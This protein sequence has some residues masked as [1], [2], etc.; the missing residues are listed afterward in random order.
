MF[1]TI[2]SALERGISGFFQRLEWLWSATAHFIGM[3]PPVLRFVVYV[4]LCLAVLCIALAH[5]KAIISNGDKWKE[6][7]DSS[8][9]FSYFCGTG[10]YQRACVYKDAHSLVADRAWLLFSAA[11]AAYHIGN[12]KSELKLRLFLLSLVHIPLVVI[13]F[14]EMIFRTVFGFLYLLVAGAIHW[15]VLA[16]L[17]MYAMFLI[18]LC[19]I[20][21][22]RRRREQHCPYCYQTFRLPGYICPSCGDVHKDLTPG[23]TGLFFARCRCGK[24]L[25]SALGT[26][27]SHLEGVCPLCGKP[28]ATTGAKEFTLQM[29]GGNASGK[30]AYLAS[31]QHI[32][33]TTGQH[34]KVTQLNLFPQEQ[35]DEL[36][37]MFMDG[38][39]SES[40]KA[41]V[42]AYSMVYNFKD[43]VKENMVIY[44]IPDEVLISGIYEQNP[45]NFAYTDGIL[46]IFDPTSSQTVREESL[47]KGEPVPNGTYSAD[48]N[49]AED[50]VVEFIQQFSR[51]SNRSSSKV[52]KIPVAVIIN[53]T[54][55]KAVK[56]KIGWD[57]IQLK[58]QGN[59]SRFYDSIS[60]ARSTICRDYMISLGMANAINNLESVFSNVQY[61]PV[62]AA[63]H[64]CREGEPLCPEGV[65]D[66]VAWIAGEQGAKIG[67]LLEISGNTVKGNG[68]KDTVVEDA[69][70]E[71]YKNAEKLLSEKEFENAEKEFRRLGN[72]QDSEMRAVAVAGQRYQY[73]KEL[74]VQKKYGLAAE[75]F[76][77]LGSYQD[78][79]D[80][81]FESLY[82]HGDICLDSKSFN[83][84]IAAFGKIGKYKDAPVKCT[85]ARYLLAGQKAENGDP[86][87][88]L[89]GYRMLGGYKDSARKAK[90]LFP[91]LI[92]KGEKRN[93]SFGKYKWRVLNANQEMA[94]VI[95]E[96]VVGLVAYH[97]SLEE[98][99]W[100]DS[101]IRKFLNSD[102]IY[103][104][105]DCE[106]RMIVPSVV[107]NADNREYGT[108]GGEDTVDAVFLLSSKEMD[109]LFSG[110]SD[111]I[112]EKGEVD[113]G[114][115]WL[116]TP[117]GSHSYASIV[118]STG[119]I[120]EGGNIVNN[121]SGG[122]RPVM[123]V[124]F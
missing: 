104:F 116:R 62:S 68:F 63:G 11:G 107:I 103:G 26:G 87:G 105:D 27:R 122:I 31:F 14:F 84:A 86:I 75:H 83:E 106:K 117:G 70:L 49:E 6:K 124:R 37:R 25:P 60:Q 9:T 100:K 1:N 85:E 118:D 113:A 39:T 16:L 22:A 41:S 72:Y 13:G 71:R 23:N 45:L 99:T 108:S 110:N 40:S 46:V 4:A 51:L 54:D 43:G 123:W 81:V 102:F 91:A 98:I 64:I 89:E 3:L 66:P 94:M 57:A 21:D 53:K 19:S 15:A 55:L 78:S 5:M 56:E 82:R 121:S 17:K 36:E 101:T 33:R 59:P 48:E 2:L 111:R 47:E 10:Q 92:K 80:Y 67:E 58:F 97:E 114:W 95:T 79:S 34:T 115:C 28:L 52:I 38:V 77:A 93:L 112:P 73:A 7:P 30:T 24:F 18:P 29:I 44:D 32:C 119:T 61:F 20:I 109:N 74:F 50:I 120:S 12:Y 90:L 96:T 76:A 35:F 42:A 8:L 69:L 88:A 65:M